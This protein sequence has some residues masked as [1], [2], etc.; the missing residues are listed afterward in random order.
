MYDVVDANILAAKDNFNGIYNIGTG[1]ET[2]VNKLCD[3]MLQA[4]GSNIN[5]I[6]GPAKMGEQR[7]SVISNNK[8]N[9]EFRW[10]PKYSLKEGLS[11]TINFFR[12]EQ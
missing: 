10:A 12:N 11:K 8:I 9:S 1:M 2:S 4:A 5:P 6:H 7:R 3:M